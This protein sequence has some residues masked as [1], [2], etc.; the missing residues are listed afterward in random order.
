V[1]IDRGRGLRISQYGKPFGEQEVAGV[2]I[3]YFFGLADPGY[4]RDIINKN[5]FHDYLLF[6]GNI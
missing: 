5:N 6:W 3:G 2:T 1:S 4:I